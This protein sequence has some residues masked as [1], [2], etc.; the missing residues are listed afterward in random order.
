MSYKDEN[1]GGEWLRLEIPINN[2][3]QVLTIMRA[4]DPE[5]VNA[6]FKAVQPLIPPVEDNHPLGSH[7]RRV[8]DKLCFLG[9]IIRLA[10]GCSWV[11]AERLIGSKVSDATMRARRDEWIKAGVF[12]SLRTETIN[13][14]DRVI[15]LDLS[16][17][18]I[19]GSLHKAPSGGEGTGKNPTDRAEL[20]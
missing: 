5:V 9:I 1:R 7:R 13:A 16:D 6:L 2:K 18:A 20:G 10:T 3:E 11:D 12:D 8:S 14:Y 19:D 15:G 17:V 4:L